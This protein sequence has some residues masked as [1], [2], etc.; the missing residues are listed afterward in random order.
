[1]NQNEKLRSAA[2]SLVQIHVLINFG[3]S[4]Q[5]KLEAAGGRVLVGEHELG[6]HHY[7]II[8]CIHQTMI[9]HRPKPAKAPTMRNALNLNPPRL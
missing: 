2:P 8:C 6:D 4:L 1:M 5:L 7:Y 9:N 3:S